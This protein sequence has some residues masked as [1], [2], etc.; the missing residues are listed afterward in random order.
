VLRATAE[1]PEFYLAA[2]TLD[3][4]AGLLRLSLGQNNVSGGPP[5]QPSL[6]PLLR[7]EIQEVALAV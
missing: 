3:E 1:C 5:I 2:E 7:F 6:A 4:Y